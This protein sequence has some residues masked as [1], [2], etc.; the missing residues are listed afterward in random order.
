MPEQA[1]YD[2]RREAIM[3]DFWT[4]KIT[5]DRADEMLKTIDRQEIATTG[6]L[7]A[8]YC[9]DHPDVKFVWGDDGGPESGPGEPYQ[10]CPVCR[11][12][13]LGI[14]MEMVCYDCTRAAG[15]TVTFG[16]WPSDLPRDEGIKRRVVKLGAVVNPADPTQSYVLDCGHTTI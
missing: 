15:R 2:E 4:G 9:D 12:E 6:R 13:H 11:D 8:D 7:A 10:Y 16:N 1:T 5:G 14:G 3:E